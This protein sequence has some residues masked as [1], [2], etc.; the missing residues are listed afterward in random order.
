MKLNVMKTIEK[1]KGEI[2]PRY[3]L[4]ANQICVLLKKADAFNLIVNSFTFGYAQ[5]YKA[6]TAELKRKGGTV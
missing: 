5:G 2:N 4:K 1:F 6:K 3:A